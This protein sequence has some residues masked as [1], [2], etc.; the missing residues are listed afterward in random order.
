MSISVLVLVTTHDGCI[1]L[2]QPTAG[3][4]DVPRADLLFDDTPDSTA[5]QILSRI[6]PEIYVDMCY[7]GLFAHDGANDTETSI[8]FFVESPQNIL[9]DAVGGTWFS[10]ESLTQISVVNPMVLGICAAWRANRDTRR[11]PVQGLTSPSI[12]CDAVLVQPY[13]PFADKESLSLPLGLCSLYSVLKQNDISVRIY[14]CNIPVSYSAMC[15]ELALT[16]ARFVGIQFH[17]AMSYNWAVR[18]CRQIRRTLPASLIVAGGELASTRS[19]ELLKSGAV[20]VVVKGEGELTVLELIRALLDGKGFENVRGIEYLDPID[21]RLRTSG[22]RAL[23]E[24]LDSLPMLSIDDFPWQ[25]YGQWSLFTSRGCPYKCMY[26]SSAAYWKHSIRYHGAPRVVDE[27]DRLV[28]RYGATDIYI[29]DDTFTL[30]AARTRDI[31]TRILARNIVVRWSC[32]TRTDCLDEQTLT[33][34]HK[35]GCVLISFGLES[36]SQQTLRDMKKG[37]LLRTAEWSLSACANLGIRTRVSVILALPGESESDV[38][39][40]LDFLLRT[41]PDEIQ[42]YGLTPHD[43]TA[44]YDNVDLLGVQVLDRDPS[45]WSRNVL[46]PIC[47]TENLKRADIIRLARHFVDVLSSAG[48]LYL[49][50]DLASKKVGARKTV[51]TSFSPVQAIASVKV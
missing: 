12:L 13:F 49:S 20:A 4:W 30:D 7:L 36:G 40:T 2:E 5:R 50:D 28:Q 34:M 31:C 11:T 15:N 27:I 32:L 8:V 6:M 38:L 18:V 19:H 26:C 16:R 44:L 48:Y 45:T 23:I 37:L 39:G 3:Y 51:A 42:L 14:D 25:N 33:L 24:D 17:S 29:A 9:H 10:V 1:W 47:E 46:R 43:G 35:A 21:G 41:Q 22:D